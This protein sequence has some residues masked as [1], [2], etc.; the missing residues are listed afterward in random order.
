MAWFIRLEHPV[1]RRDDVVHQ[2]EPEAVSLRSRVPVFDVDAFV[3]NEAVSTRAR[4]LDLQM[5]RHL[6]AAKQEPEIGS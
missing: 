6:R 5:C 4:A 3:A 2:Q 1:A